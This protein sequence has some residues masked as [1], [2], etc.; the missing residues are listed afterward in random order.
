[1]NRLIALLFLSFSLHAAGPVRVAFDSKVIEWNKRC[2][3]NNVNGAPNLTQ[4]LIA[5]SVWMGGIRSAGVYPGIILRANLMCG[6]SYGGTY[7]AGNLTNSFA[8]GSPQIP[9]INDA[10]SSLDTAGAVQSS[11]TYVETGSTG[12]LGRAGTNLVYLDTGLVPN[13]IS[14]WDNDI[15]LGAYVMGE[16]NVCILVG[17]Y[18]GSANILQI[19]VVNP[20]QNTMIWSFLPGYP[21]SGVTNGVGF[22]LG[23]RTSNSGGGISQYKNGVNSGVSST[24]NGNSGM[25]TS[26]YVLARNS[27]GVSAFHMT[28]LMGG[29]TI[30]RGLNATNQQLAV[31]NAFQQAETLL[32]RQK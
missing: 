23:T 21:A 16:T 19:A 7:G 26:I 31:Y 22:F 18:D 20:D 13:T 27:S 12:G 25:A 17:A 11:W 28:G 6:V 8:L 32:N 10:G 5:S 1:M 9:I 2:L 14:A 4:S 24:A 15:H 30:G 29:Y 3:T